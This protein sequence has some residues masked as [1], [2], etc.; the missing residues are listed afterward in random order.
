MIKSHIS[1]IARQLWRYKSYVGINVI[2]LSAAVAMSILAFLNWKHDYDFDRFHAKGERIFRIGINKE[3]NGMQH[4]I[5]PAALGQAA[6][7]GISGVQAACR[8]DSKKIT[9]KNGTEVWNEQVHFADANFFD[10]F[11]FKLLAG[12][13]NLADKS[14]IWL[15]PK[16]AQ[17]YFGNENPVGATLLLYAGESYQRNLTVGGIVQKPPTNSSLQFNFLTH[18]DN[19]VGPDNQQVQATDWAWLA[20][21]LFLVLDKPEQAAALQQSL[22]AFVEPQKSVRHDDLKAQSYWMESMPEVSRHRFMRAN[23]LR[24]NA[25]SEAIYAPLVMALLLLMTASL[26]F[27]NTTIAVSNRRLREIGLRK[28]L[29]GGQGQLVGQLLLESGAVVLF[30][31]VLGV[32]LAYWIV[33]GWNAMWKFMELDINLLNNKPLWAFL[34]GFTALTTLL[35]G[36]YP[37]FYLS[38]FRPAIIF[39]GILN[40]G[41]RNLFSRFL[42]GIQVMIALIA[43]VAGVSFSRQAAFMQAYP[44]HFSAENVIAVPLGKPE[45]YEVL[46][47]ALA[48]NPDIESISGCR[49]H[50]SYPGYRQEMEVEG[51]KK[52]VRVNDAGDGYLQLMEVTLVE[53]RLFDDSHRAENAN[54]LVVNEKFVQEIGWKG[55][56]IGKSVHLDSMQYAVIGVIK[57]VV[58]TFFE[59]VEPQVI[60]YVTEAKSL[61][62]VARC[63]PGS[64]LAVN[65]QVKTAWSSLFP[66]HPY[67]GYYNS[68]LIAESMAVTDNIH[69]IFILFSLATI[70]LTLTSLFALLSLHTLKRMKEVAVRRVLGASGG[71]IAYLLHRH[72]AV[73]LALGV[74]M[75]CFAGVALTNALINSIFKINNGVSTSALLVSAAGFAVMAAAAVS[76]VLWRALRA[77]PAEV[78]RSE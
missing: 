5:C 67:E 71:S 37:A 7:T 62:L 54:A 43:I 32:V 44:T 76:V 2:G 39:R 9:L 47:N 27:A 30:S 20:D 60:K 4:G 23:N 58:N 34:A 28:V 45:N 77:N 33:P 38:S 61:T 40:Y 63:K 72:F 3:G 35:A 17:K 14:K 59:P 64:L 10:V 12:S 22:A 55:Q 53:G 73:I 21:A 75:G 69:T 68:E 11:D 15:T 25:G 19:L 56:V 66:F 13:N 70:I 74:L 31:V 50:L 18:F 8:W 24:E 6:V 26:N 16:M 41:G 36:A 48:S 49:T 29:G 46:K 1:L 51:Q 65:T 57:D 42:L 78:L 52:D